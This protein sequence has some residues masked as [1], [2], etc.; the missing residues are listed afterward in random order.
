VAVTV[1]G[2]GVPVAVPGM[3]DAVPV[4]AVPVP[5]AEMLT[6][7]VWVAGAG[8]GGVPVVVG[9]LVAVTLPV[10]LATSTTPTEFSGTYSVAEATAVFGGSSAPA[11]V[12]GAQAARRLVTTASIASHRRVNM[13]VVYHCAPC[14]QP[15][16]YSGR[17]HKRNL[18]YREFLSN[19]WP[20][21]P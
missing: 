16:S 21:A 9:P 12:E 14:R 19:V 18:P 7:G 3:L 6:G 8:V 11:G 5:V 1:P 20:N 15:A 10:G 13:R 17:N 2:P 4:A